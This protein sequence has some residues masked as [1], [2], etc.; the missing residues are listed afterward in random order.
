MTPRMVKEHLPCLHFRVMCIGKVWV[1]TSQDHYGISRHM[2]LGITKKLESYQGRLRWQEA[3][4]RLCWGGGV[5]MEGVIEDQSCRWP[6]LM[7]ERG[8]VQPR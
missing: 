6:S 4:R 5:E 2:I 3:R 8:N 1:C 7:E